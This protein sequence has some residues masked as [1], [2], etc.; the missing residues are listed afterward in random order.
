MTPCLCSLPH[1]VLL[2]ALCPFLSLPNCC[3]PHTVFPDGGNHQTARS[4]CPALSPEPVRS[5]SPERVRGCP[6][7]QCSWLLPQRTQGREGRGERPLH[8]ATQLTQSTPSTT[9]GPQGYCEGL[10]LGRATNS[11]RAGQGVTTPKE[12]EEE[13]T[14]GP[15]CRAGGRPQTKSLCTCDWAQ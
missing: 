8:R 11:P 10:Y 15:A 7:P 5:Q 2:G 3:C 13:E 6:R 9:C 12:T 4:S 1:K 14:V